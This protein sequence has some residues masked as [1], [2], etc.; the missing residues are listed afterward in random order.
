LTAFDI[1]CNDCMAIA[2]TEFTAHAA[3]LAFF[4]TRNSRL[5]HAFTDSHGDDVTEVK[6]ILF[7]S[8]ALHI[9][10]L[11]NRSNAILLYLH[12]LSLVQQMVWST[13]TT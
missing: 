11:D 6:E 9:L 5:L 7:Y 1:N 8:I 10:T 2:G 4:D 13:I 12:S 3:D